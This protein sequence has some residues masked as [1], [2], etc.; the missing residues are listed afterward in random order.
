VQQASLIAGSD[1]EYGARLVA[2]ET[3]DISQ[4]HNLAFTLGQLVEGGLDNRRPCHGVKSVF[5]VVCPALHRVSPLSGTVEA[6]RIDGVKLLKR[7]VSDVPG[8]RPIGPDLQGCGT[9]WS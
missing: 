2:A 5:G 9:A 6:G 3:F 8:I 4:Q 7:R 1:L